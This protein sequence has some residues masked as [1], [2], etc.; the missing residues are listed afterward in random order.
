MVCTVDF[1][2]DGA[3]DSGNNAAIGFGAD[4]GTGRIPFD[5]VQQLP[6]LPR[7]QGRSGGGHIL[8]RQLAGSCSANA[9]YKDEEG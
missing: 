4:E 7:L 5:A 8:N 2:D 1:D 3:L 6:Y 9:R